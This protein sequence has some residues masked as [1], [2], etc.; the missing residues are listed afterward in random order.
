MT[1]DSTQPPALNDSPM[2]PSVLQCSPKMGTLLHCCFCVRK[3]L[4]RRCFSM[5]VLL[6]GMLVAG[7]T[8]QSHW[9]LEGKLCAILLRLWGATPPN[10]VDIQ[11]G[12]ARL[13][14]LLAC[15]VV[16]QS[17]HVI[18]LRDASSVAELDTRLQKARRVVLVGNGGIALEL[19]HALRS[20]HV[21]LGPLSHRL[22]ACL[23]SILYA[24]VSICEPGWEL[25]APYQHQT[26]RSAGQAFAP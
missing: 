14:S 15:Q 4:P 20:K 11:T 23:L 24:A 13:S 12:S 1:G 17:R 26:A 5:E 10:P 8:T 21:R 6:I 3:D 16:V 9:P 18:T 22:H 19:A 7:V 2:V 25:A